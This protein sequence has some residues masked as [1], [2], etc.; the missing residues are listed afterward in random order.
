MTQP[1]PRRPKKIADMSAADLAAELARCEK[2]LS[3]KKLLPQSVTHYRR[4][5]EMVAARIIR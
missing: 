3:N 5:L 2:A 1:R 4:R